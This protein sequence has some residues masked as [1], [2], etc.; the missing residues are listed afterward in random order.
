MTP[1]SPE[2]SKERSPFQTASVLLIAAAHCI[3]DAYQAFLAPLLPLLIEQLGL[4][5][6]L[7][8]SLDVIRKLPSLANPLVGLIADRKG[9]RYFLAL[10]PILTT[11][12]MSLMGVAPGFAYLAVL[13]LMAGTGSALFHV[14]APVMVRR[15]SADNIGRGMSLYMLGGELARTLGPLTI[16]GAVEL[17]GLHG[18]WRMIP[19][20]IVASVILY[21]KVRNVQ[22]PPHEV[23]HNET[24]RQSLLSFLPVLSALAGVLLFR[25][26]LKAAM[27]IYLPTYLTS[28]GS[29]LWMAGGA[30]S[31][32][33]FAGAGGTLFSGIISDRIGSRMALI[34]IT[35][36]NPLLMLLFMHVSGWLV[37]P[38]LI[39]SGFFLFAA[40]PVLLAVVQQNS[41]GNASFINGVYMT[42]NFVISSLMVL[43]VG[44]CA[45]SM[46]LEATFRLT[47]FIALGSIPFAFLLQSR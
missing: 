27:T 15:V 13:A 18:T 45:D 46:G 7:A 41:R 11:V 20:G 16:L 26:A 30:L 9:I 43:L 29:S 42:T 22:L 5:V 12:A 17:W 39:V 36:V 24:A 21:L 23:H 28:G 1:I 3:H 31:I 44:A 8:G 2:P 19:F 32:L 47:A 10:G 34:V 40:G 14:P 33:Q 25:S 38:V 37:I 6:M 4:S 35:I